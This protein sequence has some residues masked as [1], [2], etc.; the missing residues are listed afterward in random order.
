[1]RNLCITWTMMAAVAVFILGVWII[2]NGG[3]VAITILLGMCSVG[4]FCLGIAMTQ[5]PKP[6]GFKIALECTTLKGR[7]SDVTAPRKRS[8]SSKSSSSSQPTIKVD[9]TE[10]AEDVHNRTINK[11]KSLGVCHLPRRRSGRHRTAQ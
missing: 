6:L 7:A 9:S 2:A 10:D 1:M 11:E 8:R 3:P 5:K 4:L